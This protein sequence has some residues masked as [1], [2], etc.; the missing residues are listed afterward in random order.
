MSIAS[1]ELKKEITKAVP[2]PPTANSL[3]DVL[4]KDGSYTYDN[5]TDSLEALSD[6]VVALELDSAKLDDPKMVQAT[7]NTDSESTALTVTNKGVLTGI[8]QTVT[9][10]TAAGNAS[11][12]LTIDG[13][14]LGAIATLYFDGLGQSIHYSFH[15]RFETSLAITHWVNANSKGT[16]ST[17]VTYTTD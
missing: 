7:E 16:I 4:H 11:L 14:L 15:H 10:F 5:T 9:A 2:E 3:Q 13:A 1:E 6:A 12:R 8:T 17:T